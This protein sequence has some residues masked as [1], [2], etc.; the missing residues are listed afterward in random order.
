MKGIRI[1]SKDEL[2][3]SDYPIKSSKHRSDTKYLLFDLENTTIPISIDE[4]AVIKP[5]LGKGVK[6]G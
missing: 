4:G 5:V 6:K 2:R 1:V 3:L